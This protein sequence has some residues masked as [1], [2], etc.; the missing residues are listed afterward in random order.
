MDLEPNEDQAALLAALDQIVAGEG[1]DWHATGDWSRHLWSDRLDGALEANGLYD[2]AAEETLGP[3]AAAALIWRLAQAPVVVEAAASAMLRPFLPAD[4]P[5]PV[6]VI[7]GD[8]GAPVR[9]LPMARSVVRIGADGVSVAALSPGAV[10]GVDSIFAY[11]MGRLHAER[12]NWRPVEADP[13]LVA[14]RWRIAVAAELGGTLRGGL[15]SVLEHVRT[16]QQ[17]GQPL[18]AFQGVQ[19]RLANAATRIEAGYWLTLRA[20]GS[21]EAADAAMALGH[22]A[23][24]STSVVYDLHQFMGAMG[25]T[26]EHPLHRWTYRARLLRSDLDGAG[27][28]FRLAAARLWG[29]Q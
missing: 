2:C 14:D 11:P 13:A 10:A 28:N 5:R 15:N 20:A 23:S 4:L 3:V 17:F 12:V 29:L 21:G 22:V 24:V 27:G 19:H 16:R 1:G 6:A 8:V 26:L 25:L 9:Y 18:G 7:A